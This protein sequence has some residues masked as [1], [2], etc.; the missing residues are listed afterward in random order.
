M[1]EKGAETTVIG[2]PRHKKN[3]TTTEKPTVFLKKRPVEKERGMYIISCGA[4][5]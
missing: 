1:K 5:S 3:K 2:L 4:R